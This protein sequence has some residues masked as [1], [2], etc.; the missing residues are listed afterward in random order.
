MKTESAAKDC[1]HCGLPIPAARCHQ[2]DPFCCE[3]CLRVY[4]LIRGAGLT[5]YYALGGGSSTPAATL[6]PDSFAWLERLLPVGLAGD[7]TNAPD[8]SQ[9]RRLTLDV[10]GIHCAACVWL[11][12]ELFLRRPGAC[13]LLVNPALGQAEVTW[14]P[15][16]CDLRDY[17]AEAE[18]FG[19]A[20]GLRA[21]EASHRSR[22]LLVRLGI[23]AAAA[24][25]VMIFSLC[26]YAGLGPAD[27]RL[28]AFFGQLNLGL[29]L[30]AWRREDRAGSGGG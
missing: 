2:G 5:R 18:R 21:K 19:Y 13:E 25:N 11:L 30:A 29:T 26:F 17:L 10:Q 14:I 4:E 24:M 16:Q 23:C 7:H 8:P 27:G 1:I 12:R 15:A 28:Y 9:P 20:F 22:G 3:G 6:R